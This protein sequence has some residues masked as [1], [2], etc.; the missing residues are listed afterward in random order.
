MLTPG[1]FWLGENRKYIKARGLTCAVRS[2]QTAGPAPLN[3]GL[4]GARADDT[5]TEADF[6]R[7]EDGVLAGGDG[8]LR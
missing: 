6:A 2:G 3:V 1:L 8:A 7:V 5:A 4:A